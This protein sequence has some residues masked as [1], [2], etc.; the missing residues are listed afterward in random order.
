MS[1]IYDEKLLDK[2]GL[3]MVPSA[4]KGAADEGN[5]GGF[6]GKVYS[7]LPAQ[8]EIDVL[9]IDPSNLSSG[10]SYINEEIVSDGSA[11]NLFSEFT[12]LAEQGKTYKLTLTA[13]LNGSSLLIF[14]GGNTGLYIQEGTNTYTFSHSASEGIISFKSSVDNGFTL[15]NISLVQISNG[16]FDFSRGSDATRVNSQGYIESVQVYSDDILDNGELNNTLGNEIIEDSSFEEVGSE[17]ITNGDFSNGFGTFGDWEDLDDHAE[18]TDGELIITHTGSGAHRVRQNNVVSQNNIYKV[19]FDLVESTLN[20]LSDLRF[21]NGAAYVYIPN[22][23]GVGTITFYY[24]PSGTNTAFYFSLLSNAGNEAGQYVKID[25]V[26]VKQAAPDWTFNS[27]EVDLVDDN[28]QIK[29]SLTNAT[30]TAVRLNTDYYSTVANAEYEITYTISNYSSGLFRVQLGNDFGEWRGANGTY[31]EIL[32]TSNTTQL[33]LGGN[34]GFNGDIHNISLKRVTGL[35]DWNFQQGH[36]QTVEG[37]VKFFEGSIINQQT[38]DADLNGGKIRVSYTLQ[39][40]QGTNPRFQLYVNGAWQ[41][42]TTENGTFTVDYT[43]ANTIVYLR[44]V[45]SANQGTFEVTN[46]SVKKITDDTDIPRLDYSDG[47]PTLLL[48]PERIN[49]FPQSEF[50]TNKLPTNLTQ[51]I[52][53]VDSPIKDLKYL[54]LKKTTSG[55]ARIQQTESGS[56]VYTYSAF[57]KQGSTNGNIALFACSFYGTNTLNVKFD[58]STGEFVNTTGSALVDY[59]FQDFGN[60]SYRVFVTFNYNNVSTGTEVRTM[61]IFLDDNQLVLNEYIYITGVQ[62]EEGSY[63]TS[64]IPTDGNT[65]TRLT[66]FC[67]NAGDSTIFNDSEGV[68]YVEMAALDQTRDSTFSILSLND[69]NTQNLIQIYYSTT[70]NRI[71]LDLKISGST[72]AGFFTEVNDRTKFNKIAFKYKQ[73]DF[74]YWINGEK[75]G[76]DTSGNVFSDGTLKRISFHGG[77]TSS[78]TEAKVRSLLYFNEALSDAEL[79]YITSSDID[80]VLQ[81]N[82]LKATMFGDTYEDGHVEDRLNELF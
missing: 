38:G 60:G 66:D 43:S 79:E 27:G 76:T 22:L 55:I 51:T 58:L 63:P 77:N 57:F 54:K 41:D 17:L 28:G 48:E 21:Y 29:A 65:V 5:T 78:K 19:T 6:L 10:V 64:Y 68:L 36:T 2:T 42:Q 56:G 70:T 25:N 13:E 44:N 3:A 7:V 26:S 15:S 69:G 47:C 30:S 4:Y 11:D 52:S 8:T 75:I 33:W 82:K 20:D 72:Q 46:V 18:I 39:N 24:S 53:D 16:D 12:R 32:S 31:R 40:V 59:G 81:N 74:S 35:E 67:D 62:I 49:V 34:T 50:L 23:S 61:A 14:S 1:V 80:V 37:G 73:N 9:D 45:S 71:N